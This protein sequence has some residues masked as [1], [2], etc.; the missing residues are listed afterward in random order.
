MLQVWETGLGNFGVDQLTR[1]GEQCLTKKR[2]KSVRQAGIKLE[3]L[4]SAFLMLGV[5]VGL[6][7]ICFLIEI[8]TYSKAFRT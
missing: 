7:S 8:I 4:T 5:G 3:D 2:K 6:A 1:G